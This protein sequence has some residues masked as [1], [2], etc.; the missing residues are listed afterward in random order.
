MGPS[1]ANLEPA[2]GPIIK[3]GNWW[4]PKNKADFVWAKIKKWEDEFQKKNPKKLVLHYSSDGEPGE[5]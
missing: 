3:E 2:K 1:K 4:R 5:L